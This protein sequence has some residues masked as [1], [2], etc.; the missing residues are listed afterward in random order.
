LDLYKALKIAKQEYELNPSRDNRDALFRAGSAIRAKRGDYE[1]DRQQAK[2]VEDKLLKEK[3][4]IH[5][6]IM[7]QL[8][9]WSMRRS[10]SGGL[11]YEIRYSSSKS[12]KWFLKHYNFTAEEWYEISN[13]MSLGQKVSYL[14]K[15]FDIK[16]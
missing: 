1:R 11:L 2:E 5:L 9:G 12:I 4:L 10:P 14:I 3:E 13:S 8:G 7:N 16:R 6:R 15:E